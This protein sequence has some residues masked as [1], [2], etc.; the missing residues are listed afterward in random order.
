MDSDYPASFICGQN[1]EGWYVASE[2]RSIKAT[3][4]NF[5]AHKVLTDLLGQLVLA[6]AAHS[7]VEAPSSIIQRLVPALPADS[8]AISVLALH[9]GRHERPSELLLVRNQTW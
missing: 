7:S 2:G 3:P 1:V 5:G 6:T 8:D 9:R 4:G